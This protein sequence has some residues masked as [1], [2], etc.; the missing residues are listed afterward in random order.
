M[1]TR[2]VTA[3]TA[4][5]LAVPFLSAP[6]G[7]SPGDHRC[8]DSVSVEHKCDASFA[9]DHCDDPVTTPEKCDGAKG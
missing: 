8:D 1:R 2:L 7:A 9:E 5:L 4:A 3:L 6:A